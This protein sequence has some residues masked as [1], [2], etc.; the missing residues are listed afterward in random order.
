MRHGLAGIRIAQGEH[1]IE[2]R[3]V[4]AGKILPGLRMETVGRIPREPKDLGHQRI[5]LFCWMHPRAETFEILPADAV[6]DGF[7]KNAP[8]GITIGQKEDVV[9]ALCHGAT[10]YSRE[11]IAPSNHL[12]LCRFPATLG[13]E[14]G[15]IAYF[16]TRGL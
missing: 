16:G 5:E 14:V 4:G 6:H 8:C 10:P 7:G 2:R 1:E 15:P 3:S 12:W 11:V 9:A 13:A